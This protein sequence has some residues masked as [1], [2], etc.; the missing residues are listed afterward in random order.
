MTSPRHD[1]LAAA[2]PDGG[3]RTKAVLGF[4]AFIRSVIG[5]HLIHLE[6]SIVDIHRLLQI[7]ETRPCGGT[8]KVHPKEST[9]E[10]GLS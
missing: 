2:R 7:V 10:R 5:S 9:H 4:H 6:L 8:E 1:K 3:A